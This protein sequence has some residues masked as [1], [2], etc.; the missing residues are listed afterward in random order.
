MSNEPDKLDIRRNKLT[1]E[2]IKEICNLIRLNMYTN[3]ACSALG[4]PIS[5]YYK[6]V[7]EG[8]EALI[9]QFQIA[10]VAEYKNEQL[11]EREELLVELVESIKEAEGQAQ[12]KSIG[13]ITKIALGEKTIK[14]I[15]HLNDEGKIIKVEESF[16]TPQWSAFAWILERR[17]QDEWGK[18]DREADEIERLA[19]RDNINIQQTE[20]SEI[21]NDA[22]TPNILDI[23]QEAGAIG[24]PRDS[25]GTESKSKV[26]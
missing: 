17:Y 25:E 16:N 2:L 18:K 1:K 6:W 14:R 19:I 11:T 24:P 13:E 5:S 26:E 8:K 20:E 22:N 7:G 15:E 23:L 9:K 12:F 10:N 4:V 21:I 3:R